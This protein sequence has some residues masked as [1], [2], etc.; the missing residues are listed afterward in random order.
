M[1]KLIITRAAQNDLNEIAESV[2]DFTYSVDSVISLHNA[3]H[4]KF[5]FIQFMPLGIGRKIE[6]ESAREAFCR[7]YRIVYEVT[8]SAVIIL[9]VI[10]SSRMRYSA[11][12]Y[13]NR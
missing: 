11:E 10:H 12:F 3:L 13:R 7:G 1:L 9:S 6:N 5:S 8:E 2:F 4:Q